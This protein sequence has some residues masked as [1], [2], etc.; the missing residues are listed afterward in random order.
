MRICCDLY[1]PA[2]RHYTALLAADV[3]TAGATVRL[4]TSRWQT[5]VESHVRAWRSD[6]VV[7]SALAYLA[8]FR[9]SSAAYRG[10]G[11]RIEVV[12]LATP[13]VLS[14]FGILDRFLAEAALGSNGRYV[15]WENH[16]TC[17]RKMLS[18]VAVIEAEQWADRITVVR[19]DGTVLYDNELVGVV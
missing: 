18:T 13:Q 16:G 3:R 6:A 5:E 14:Q 17:A 10:S 2:H 4:A 7:E 8:E 19:R 9:A 11:H 15:P 1:K 12:A